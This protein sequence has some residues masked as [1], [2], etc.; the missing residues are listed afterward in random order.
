MRT[1]IL[2]LLFGGICMGQARA[3]QIRSLWI[4]YEDLYSTH[5]NHFRG[6]SVGFTRSFH[7]KW[8]LGIGVE[9]SYAPSHDDNGFNLSQLNFLPITIHQYYAPFGFGSGKPYL[10]GSQG[11]SFVWYKKENA[12]LPGLPKEIREGG[13]YGFLGLGLPYHFGNRNAIFA[14]MGLKAF[15]L[16][17]NNLDVNPH[18]IAGK[19]G[20]RF[21]F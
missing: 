14:E 13:I 2:M 6:A 8:E 11:W 12:A 10:H 5:R 15:H 1:T 9:Y 21:N 20:Y 16:S 19:L 7:P 4:Q 3:Q 18:G 17:F